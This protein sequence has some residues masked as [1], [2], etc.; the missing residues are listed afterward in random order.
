[1]SDMRRSDLPFALTATL[2]ALVALW[3]IGVVLTL[4]PARDP[5]HVP[6]WSAVALAFGALAAVSFA[7][8]ASRAHAA[9]RA[10][11][12]GS[13]AALATG[14][15]ALGHTVR[16]EPPHFEGYLVLMAAILAAHGAAGCV[17]WLRVRHTAALRPGR[18]A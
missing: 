14:L 17:W 16:A 3:L 12:L 11:A 2:M 5:A 7:A 10:A 4:L 1:M 9:V 15:L 8:L 6:F 13:V 18:A